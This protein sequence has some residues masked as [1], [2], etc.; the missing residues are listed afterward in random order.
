[1]IPDFH[2]VPLSG[3]RG[4]SRT[5]LGAGWR[6]LEHPGRASPAQGQQHLSHSCPQGR[7]LPPPWL[8]TVHVG[9]RGC[10]ARDT[11][12]CFQQQ[13]SP[14]SS[15]TIPSQRHQ[16][17]KQTRE[18]LLETWKHFFFFLQDFLKAIPHLWK[19]S[20][21][22]QQLAVPA[23]IA[24]NS[25]GVGAERCRCQGPCRGILRKMYFSGSRCGKPDKI[26]ELSWQRIVFSHTLPEGLHF[27]SHPTLLP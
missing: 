4:I 24:P 6:C 23:G 16:K 20:P 9:T 8:A 1:M 19:A 21:A 10:P 3:T 12:L 7:D 25:A 27:L 22:V 17:G 2:G 15:T 18:L 14:F 11:R 13:E 5:G 26:E